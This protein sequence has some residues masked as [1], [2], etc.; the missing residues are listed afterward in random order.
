M[1]VPTLDE[2]KNVSA[3]LER[4]RRTAGVFEVIVADGGSTDGTVAAAGRLAPFARVVRG[5]PGRGQQLRTGAAEATGEVLLFLHADNVPPWDV[6]AQVGGAVASGHVGG[7]FRLRYPGGG[8][9]GRWLEAL[10]PAYRGIRR[11]YGD[12]GI[13]VRR[14][15]YDAC[16]GMPWIPIMEDVAF[17]QRME[18]AGPTAYLPG[19][20]ISASRRWEGRP[21]RTLV[22]WGSMQIAFAR[23]VSPWRLAR[24]YKRRG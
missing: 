8:F 10:A 13:F 15:V 23:G 12:S 5:E 20:M 16:G 3:L 7:N 17:V 18:K 19:P 21:L 9:L 14:D 11:Y 2:E 1:I 4:L 6:A 22:L 24:L